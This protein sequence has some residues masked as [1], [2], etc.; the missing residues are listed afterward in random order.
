M[1]RFSDK[2]IASA[3]AR[4]SFLCAMCGTKLTGDYEGHHIKP[5]SMGGSDELSNCAMLCHDCHRNGAHGGN[6]R[7]EFQLDMEELKYFK[8][9]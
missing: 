2:V 8:G 4:Q 9:R 3:I 7:N 1:A 6:M 5:K